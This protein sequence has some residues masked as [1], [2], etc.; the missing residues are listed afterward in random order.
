MLDLFW[1][2]LICFPWPITIYNSFA[3]IKLLTH[4]CEKF[5]FF[6][7]YN[8]QWNQNS[9]TCLQ[10]HKECCSSGFYCQSYN[11]SCFWNCSTPSLAAWA[12]SI[13]F[14][15]LAKMVCVGILIQIIW[16]FKF[17][18]TFL[19]YWEADLKFIAHGLLKK[20]VNKKSFSTF[21]WK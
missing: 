16:V 12:H 1:K 9:T 5:F 7:W 19:T 14:Y 21:I 10:T 3:Y 13:P 15:S 20:N 6:Q 4:S 8:I 11:P 17:Q 2:S 18:D